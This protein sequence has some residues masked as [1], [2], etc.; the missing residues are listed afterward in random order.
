M[1]FNA[2][3]GHNPQELNFNV[4]HPRNDVVE[5]KI[6]LHVPSIYIRIQG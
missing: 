4:Q 5:H 6:V 3:I 2:H 1:Q